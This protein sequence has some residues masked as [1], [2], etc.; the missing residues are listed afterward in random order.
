[1]GPEFLTTDEIAKK[2]AVHRNTV[3]RWIR[4]GKLEAH[5]DAR[6]WL[7]LPADFYNFL[8]RERREISVITASKTVGVQVEHSASMGK[9]QTPISKIPK[10]V[11]VTIG[12]LTGLLVIIGLLLQF[13]SLLQDRYMF[14]SQNVDQATQIAILNRQLEI[15][16]TQLAVQKELATLQAS[17]ARAGPAATAVAEREKELLATQEALEEA[18]RRL[19]ATRTATTPQVSRTPTETSSPTPTFILFEMTPFPT[20]ILT[21]WNTTPT[22]T[23]TPLP[24][25]TLTPTFLPAVTPTFLPSGTPSQ[26]SINFWADHTNLSAGECTTLYW[27]VEGV[28]EIY[29]N[30]KGVIGHDS[31]QV[32]PK[33]TTLYVLSVVH[34]DGTIEQRRI[35]VHVILPPIPSLTSTPIAPIPTP[36]PTFEAT[37]PPTLTSTPTATSTLASKPTIIVSEQAVSLSCEQAQITLTAQGQGAV[38]EQ[39]LPLD[40]II[41][42]D[43]SE[44]MSNAGSDQRQTLTDLKNAAKVLVDQL[45]PALDQVGLVSYSDW[46]AVDHP[47]SFDYPSVKKAIDSLVA[48]GKTNISDAILKAQQ[49]LNLRRRSGAISVIVFLSDGIANRGSDDR[50]CENWPD[51]PTACIEEAIKQ[52]TVAKGQ[53]IVIYAVAVNLKNIGDSHGQAV[54]QVART[55]MGTIASAVE[56]YFEA[57][58]TNTLDSALNQI[59]QGI[60]KVAGYNVKIIVVLPNGVN[61]ISDSAMPQPFIIAE[62]IFTW[63]LGLVPI[64]EV[65]KIIFSVRVDTPGPNVLIS[66][67][68]DTRVEYLDYQH[69]PLDVPFPETHLEIESCPTPTPIYTDTVAPTSTPTAT[70]TIPAPTNT[71]TPA[72]ILTDTLTPTVT[73]PS[74]DTPIPT[75]TETPTSTATPLSTDTPIPT[76]TETPTVT[77]TPSPFPTDTPA[78]AQTPTLTPTTVPQ[79][80]DTPTPTPV[81]TPTVA[82]TVSPEPPTA[83]LE[84]T[85]EPSTPTLVPSTPTSEPPTETPEPPT[86]T[87]TSDDGD[88]NH[89]HGNDNDHED[90]DNPGQG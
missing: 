55:T 6:R 20:A 27:D 76:A 30:G 58:D 37:L 35:N 67:Y 5:R 41:V 86:P 34:Q 25:P 4:E 50:S 78:L 12:G 69:S 22:I 42:L 62:R 79:P 8:E 9:E 16:S 23:N 17:E 66:T 45:D 47:L 2:Q 54:A 82:P 1:M 89:G 40:L 38:E 3:S 71:S 46:G 43:R 53:D 10:Y 85:L 56:N 77:P 39:R 31:K 29:L 65:R 49:E 84:A 61:Y 83:T 80:T 11:W 68:P 33:I 74:T 28:R 21:V 72:Q 7:V 73:P 44:S 57:S 24:R 64:D 90:N 63:K 32:C 15:Q 75:A 59:A 87:S 52:A 36:T 51:T 81:G 88:Q 70:P 13:T 60:V 14:V 26:I 18:Q 48:N 19:E